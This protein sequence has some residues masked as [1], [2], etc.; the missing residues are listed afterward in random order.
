MDLGGGG[1]ILGVTFLHAFVLW[2]FCFTEYPLYVSLY[3]LNEDNECQP[4]ILQWKKADCTK[5]K[6]FLGIYPFQSNLP[7]GLIKDISF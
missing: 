2:G 5:P 3:T 4:K 6:C 7:W 1:C